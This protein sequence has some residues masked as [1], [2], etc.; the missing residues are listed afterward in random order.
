MHSN[1]IFW[2]TKKFSSLLWKIFTYAW[3]EQLTSASISLYQMEY[4]SW[5]VKVA[6]GPYMLENLQVH[7]VF[8]LIILGNPRTMAK[9][10]FNT[11]V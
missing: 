1:N 4:F 11:V 6:G 3:L 10:L 2:C 8:K 7:M 5:I 9:D